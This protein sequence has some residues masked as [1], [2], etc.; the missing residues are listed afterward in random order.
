MEK[1][2]NYVCAYCHQMFPIWDTR[3]VNRGIAGKE[4]RTCD[5]CADAACNSGKIIQCDA[6]GEYFTPDVL[7]DEEICGHSFTAC[8]A[9][10]KDVVD[11]MTREEFE[12]EHQPCRY[13]VVVRNVDGS[14]RGYVVS[15]D[16]SAGINGVVQKLAGKVNL[17]HAASIIIAEIL[18]GEDEF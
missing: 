3:L 14:Q 6:C 4:Q 16:S 1:E 12:K 10:G 5:S 7:H 17:D 2:N 18:T 13:T 8:P 15:V 9:C 11:C